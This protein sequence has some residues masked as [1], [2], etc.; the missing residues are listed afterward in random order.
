LD[1]NWTKFE[2]NW[3]PIGLKSN[4]TPHC[5]LAR[6]LARGLF[7][8][9]L[10]FAFSLTF[11]GP[12]R[13]QAQA[14]IAVA[15]TPSP[16]PPT[17]RRTRRRGCL[18][19]TSTIRIP[20][21][22]ATPTSRRSRLR[23]A[24]GNVSLRNEGERLHKPY[25]QNHTRLRSN[26]LDRPRLIKMVQHPEHAPS[27][28]QEDVGGRLHGHATAALQHWA[29]AKEVAAMPACAVRRRIGWQRSGRRRARRPW[30]WAGTL[31]HCWSKSEGVGPG[32]AASA[33]GK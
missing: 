9:L 18:R 1:S 33:L 7:A 27:L 6:A 15:T 21:R 24:A 28:A 16:T 2:S 31:R 13:A 17:T 22:A 10:A 5:A 23:C 29:E 30:W 11:E 8:V 4:W 26:P 19:R 20:P 32:S 12:L 14:F 25:G 3:T